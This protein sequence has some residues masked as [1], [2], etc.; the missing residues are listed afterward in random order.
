M[1]ELP[2]LMTEKETGETQEENATFLPG[3]ISFIAKEINVEDRCTITLV[4]GLT[5][6]VGKPYDEVVTTIRTSII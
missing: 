3:S 4:S 6:V 1:I 2:I 5:L